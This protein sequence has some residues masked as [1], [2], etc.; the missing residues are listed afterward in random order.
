[1][2]C[3]VNMERARKFLKK[4]LTYPFVRFSIVGGA[5]AVIDFILYLALIYSG[6]H[7]LLAVAVAFSVGTV[8][9]F[10]FEKGFVFGNQAKHRA[11]QFT[12]FEAFSV[13]DFL[14]NMFLMFIFVDVL[15]QGPVASK[16]ITGLIAFFL[17]Y[18]LH[19]DITFNTK[20]FQ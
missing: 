16:I 3:M 12:V 8:L 4:E 10:S 7:Y 1:M 18:L 5:V 14:L 9:K 17:I 15:A 2:G 19:K 20:F 11:K 6:F 13:V